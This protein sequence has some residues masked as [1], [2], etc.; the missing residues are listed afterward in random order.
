MS[1][2]VKAIFLVSLGV[3]WELIKYRKQFLKGF[4]CI[5]TYFIELLSL[6]FS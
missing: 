2:F 4:T 5:F 3:H 1:L 6:I